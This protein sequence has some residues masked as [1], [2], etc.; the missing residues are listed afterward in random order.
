MWKFF[1]YLWHPKQLIEA[2]KA[3]KVHITGFLGLGFALVLTFFA[4][5]PVLGIVM[6][7]LI[8]ED[9]LSM[10]T[11]QRSFWIASV[12]LVGVPLLKWWG[13]SLL[14]YA[15]IRGGE[16][17]KPAPTWA[18]VLLARSLGLVPIV[19]LLPIKALLLPARHI[20]AHL[21]FPP[22]AALGLTAAHTVVPLPQFS[23]FLLSSPSPYIRPSFVLAMLLWL[24]TF[25]LTWRKLRQLCDLSAGF[26]FRRTLF[27]ALV[28]E[29]ISLLL[30]F[31]FFHPSAL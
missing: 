4:S 8:A 28:W 1:R 27:A 17:E 30:I 13:Y 10:A 21:F 14:L 24:L 29:A 15:S 5:L 18:T 31:F 26:L 19:L 20:L 22:I 11:I 7:R 2:I 3:H 6:G 25:W 12:L 23:F 9:G 16:G